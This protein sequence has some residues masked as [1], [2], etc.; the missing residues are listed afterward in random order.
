MSY[1]V[2]LSPDG[3]KNLDGKAH[4]LNAILTQI[5]QRHAGVTQLLSVIS[6]V[7]GK[8]PD[9]WFSYSLA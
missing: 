5:P 6:L 7:R 9:L 4:G 2:Q 1:C 3:F 8:L